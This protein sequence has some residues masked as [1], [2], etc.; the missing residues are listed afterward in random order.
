M[1]GG[2]EQPAPAPGGAE[3][4]ALFPISETEA[5]NRPFYFLASLSPSIIDLPMRYVQSGFR[6]L[7]KTA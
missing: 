6:V 1:Q 7:F 2:A 4:Q 5:S 3:E